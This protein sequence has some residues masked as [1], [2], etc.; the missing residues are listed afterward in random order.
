MRMSYRYGLLL[1]L[2]VCFVNTAN[3]QWHSDSVTS[4]AVCTAAGNQQGPKICTDGADGAIIVWEDYRSA[5]TWDIYAQHL[6]AKGVPQWGTNGVAVCVTG[7]NQRYPVIAEDDSGGVYVVWEDDRTAT[8]GI[9]LYGQHVR[10]DGTLAYIS[11]GARVCADSSNSPNARRDQNTVNMCHDG[12]GNAFVVWEDNRATAT[13]TR[14]D[15]YMNK[16]TPTT[17]AWGKTGKAIITQ[18]TQQLRPR[19]CDDGSGG[20]FLAWQNNVAVPQSIWGTRIDANGTVLWGS[21]TTLQGN[22]IYRAATYTNLSRNVSVS[23]DGQEFLLAWEETTTNSGQEIRANRIKMDSTK[24]WYTPAD[25]TWGYV[26]DQTWP[27]AFSDDSVGGSP[28]DNAGLLVVYQSTF[29]DPDISFTRVLPNGADLRPPVGTNPIS[30]CNQL[31]GQNNFSAVKCGDGAVMVAW[32]DARKG[33]G[34]SSV[35]IQRV[36]RSMR[37]AFPTI[38]T[39]STWGLPISVNANYQ[40]KQVVLAPRSNGAIAAWV[41]TRNGTYDIYAQ[42]VFNDG[43]LPIE[44]NGFAA[45][46]AGDFVSL[47]WKT[48]S[49]TDNA[50]FEVERRTVDALGTPTGFEVIASYREQNSLRGATRSNI[51]RNYNYTDAPGIAG[52]YEYRIA[53]VALNGIRSTHEAKKIEF[54]TASAAST[55][56]L[57]Q[58]Q[59]NPFRSTTAVH[60]TVP[61][62]ANVDLT[63]MDILGRV[64]STPVVHRNF[65]AGSHQIELNAEQFASGASAG[66][67]F[68]MLTA[69]DPSTGSLLWTSDKA[70]MMQV[71]K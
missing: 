50:G 54:K 49:E 48:A 43:T 16:L 28:F 14:P 45:K 27:V 17:V 39:S 5:S 42:V 55:W 44:F 35:Y 8:N 7:Y 68:F 58:N 2:A 62:Q 52:T 61:M 63:V 25:V 57:E 40:A 65:T 59:P 66:T 56:S 60:F 34:D 70:R 19:L 30:V 3:A 53:D 10:A 23:R 20:C 51:T 67:Y 29:A 69:Y 21:G 6:N 31:R 46:Q 71:I 38:G 1:L 36:D 22:E 24:L 4:T 33:V 32:T 12:F 18:N 13:A 11:T 37:R 26:G 47:D 41:D 9:D 64:V 15:L